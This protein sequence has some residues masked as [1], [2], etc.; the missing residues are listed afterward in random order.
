[1]I[2]LSDF[3]KE[4]YPNFYRCHHG[5]VKKVTLVLGSRIEVDGDAFSAHELKP[6]YLAT[7]VGQELLK[8]VEL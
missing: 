1:M 3:D 8:N 7:T 4:G 6:S 5:K 2:Q